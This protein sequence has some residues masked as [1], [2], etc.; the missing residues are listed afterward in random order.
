MCRRQRPPGRVELF[1][2]PECE[3]GYRSSS[4]LILSDV[5]Q[6]NARV[7]RSKSPEEAETIGVGFEPLEERGEVV[8]LCLC[9]GLGDR[10]PWARGQ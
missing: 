4:F 10:E 2:F 9:G 3:S 7:Q 6:T 5:M 1:L 8:L